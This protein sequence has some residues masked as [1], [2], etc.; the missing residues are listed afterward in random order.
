MLL[1]ETG[2]ETRATP[3]MGRLAPRSAAR[4]DM[5]KGVW[6]SEAASA[7]EL[8]LGDRKQRPKDAG[9]R[10]SSGHGERK[11]EGASR[12]GDRSA[13]VRS[14]REASEAEPVQRAADQWFLGPIRRLAGPSRV[15]PARA[16]HEAGSHQSGSSLELDPG[17]DLSPKGEQITSRAHESGVHAVTLRPW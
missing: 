8:A 3:F 12:S 7:G 5:T 17:A 13:N 1:R 10:A 9:A 11:R 15:T 16:S 6:A 14:R 2:T 4:I